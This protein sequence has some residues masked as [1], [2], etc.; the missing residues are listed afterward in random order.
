MFNTDYY[1]IKNDD[2]VYSNTN[3][4]IKKI[5]LSPLKLRFIAHTKFIKR[6]PLRF[7]C[8]I[9]CPSVTFVKDKTGCKIFESDMKC[10]VD[11]LAWERL[12]RKDGRFIYINKP[13]MGHRV[14][15]E[16][17]TTE[18]IKE[19]IRT[20]EDYQMFCKFWPKLIAKFINN[21]YKNSEKSNDIKIK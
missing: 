4:N 17:T 3:L 19:N 12:S 9:C 6:L 8:S 18:I 16:S 13:L 1:E 2:K 21:F 14:H 10:D 11:W 15:E 20:K 7:G 5:L